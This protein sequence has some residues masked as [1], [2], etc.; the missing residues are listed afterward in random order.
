MQSERSARRAAPTR[1]IE[2]GCRVDVANSPAA[3]PATTS[4]DDDRHASARPTRAGRWRRRDCAPPEPRSRARAASCS[5]SSGSAS[6]SRFIATNSSIRAAD[7]GQLGHPPLA[8]G[9]PGVLVVPDRLGQQLILGLEVVDDQRRADP[10]PLGDVG[11]AVSAKPRSEMTSRAAAIICPR[12]W[13]A[14]PI[15]SA[16]SPGRSVIATVLSSRSFLPRSA[17]HSLAM[18]ACGARAHSCALPSCRYGSSFLD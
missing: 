3:C 9:V 13:S 4:D 10:D 17:S 15:A 1:K 11:D 5:S 6:G 14:V 18:S 7:G 16:P 2:N 8:L 12:R